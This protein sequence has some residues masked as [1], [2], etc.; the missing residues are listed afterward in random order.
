MNAQLG[1]LGS[2]TTIPNSH[3]RKGFGDWNWIRTFGPPD[4]RHSCEQQ[5]YHPRRLYRNRLQRRT[6]VSMKWNPTRLLLLA[7][8][9]E[10]V[11]VVAIW[12]CFPLYSDLKGNYVRRPIWAPL[13]IPIGHDYDRLSQEDIDRLSQIPGQREILESMKNS[14]RSFSATPIWIG[15]RYG[16]P[17]NFLSFLAFA[18]IAGYLYILR[19]VG[20]L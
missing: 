10:V 3:Q 7:G 2:A 6:S 9:T 17:K 13:Q 5:P 20:I 16:P 8:F 18:S 1:K 15:N 12:I 19:R 11:L 14:P 4:I